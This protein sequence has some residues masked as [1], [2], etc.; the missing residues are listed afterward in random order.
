[1]DK[2]EK[3]RSENPVFIYKSMNITESAGEVT[4]DYVFSMPG[5]ADF[6]PSWSFP[7]PADVSITGDLTFERL[8]FSLG[9]AEAVSYWKAACPPTVRVLCGE[10]DNVQI[11]WWKKLW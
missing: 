9:M 7:K 8:A 10:L 5:L 6:N 4:V 1:M 3:F 2:F 11:N